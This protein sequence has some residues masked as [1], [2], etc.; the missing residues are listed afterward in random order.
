ML[1]SLHGRGCNPSLDVQRLHEKYGYS[2]EGVPPMQRHENFSLLNRTRSLS[3][4]K[5]GI[6][7]VAMWRVLV[8]MAY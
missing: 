4:E 6:R 7:F 2:S 5:R 1:A 3:L 8:R